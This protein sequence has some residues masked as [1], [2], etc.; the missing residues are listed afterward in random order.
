[1]KSVLVAAMLVLCTAVWGQ[2]YESLKFG[3]SL[4]EV[5]KLFPGLVKVAPIGKMESYSQTPPGDIDTASRG[6]LF[7][8]NVLRVVVEVSRIAASIETLQH[9]LENFVDRVSMLT[10]VPRSTLFEKIELSSSETKGLLEHIRYE[11][12]ILGTEK[13]PK[14]SIE[15]TVSVQYMH[16]QGIYGTK[17]FDDGFV[18]TSCFMYP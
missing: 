17:K 13:Y 10:G 1:M 8:N 5:E 2:G 9:I 15:I 12:E 14:L 16:G 18:M 11:C 4:A 6:F 3:A 7:E